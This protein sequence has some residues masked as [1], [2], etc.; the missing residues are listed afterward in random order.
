MMDSCLFQ[1][2]QRRAFPDVP[3]LSTGRVTCNL[4]L[5]NLEIGEKLSR[6]DYCIVCIFFIYNYFRGMN[7]IYIHMLYVRIYL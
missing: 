2:T 3:E 5:Y 1:F 6:T 7:D 4:C